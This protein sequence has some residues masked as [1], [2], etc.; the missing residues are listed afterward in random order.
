MAKKIELEG[1]GSIVI[2]PINLKEQ[3]FEVVDRNGNPLTK[4]M[5]GTRAK[6]A[7]HNTQG[8]EVPNTQLC[9]KLVVEGEEIVTPKFKPLPKIDQEDI[10]EQDDN[11]LVYRAIE[12][13]FYSVITES[14]RLKKLILDGNKSLTFPF[15]AGQ[16]WK[17]WNAMLTNWNDRL[18][19][20]ACRGDLQKELE[21]YTEE[22]VEFEIEVIPQT[23]NVKKLLKAIV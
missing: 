7:Y 5:V 16:G 20:V 23:R 19:L 14:P 22:T 9:R 17:V 1:Y 18:L 13:K 4:E 21:K 3:E 8:S 11:G 15:I 10:Q 2:Q 12:R 6:T